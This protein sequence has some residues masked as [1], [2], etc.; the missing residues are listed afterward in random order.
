MTDNWLDLEPPKGLPVVQLPAPVLNPA[1]AQIAALKRK[2]PLSHRV[3]AACLLEARLNNREAE[4]LMKARGYTQTPAV[5]GQWRRK[6]YM[7]QLI[8]MMGDEFVDTVGSSATKVLMQ[9]DSI[10]EYGGEEITLRDKYGAAIRDEDGVPIKAK[11]D[12]HLALKANELIGK[13]HRLWGD[14]DTK[15]VVVNIVDLTG[16]RRVRVDPIEAQAEIEDGELV[17]GTDR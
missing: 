17:D 9:V 15:R 11:R 13:K 12:P 5:L 10:A 6:P 2:L 8:E 14:D 3:Y 1:R 7:R 4:R 16:E